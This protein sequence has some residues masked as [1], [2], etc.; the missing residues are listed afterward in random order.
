[1]HLFQ[2]FRSF[3]FSPFVDTRRPYV[4]AK[5]RVEIFC[6]RE[7]G[8]RTQNLSDH[9]PSTLTPSKKNTASRPLVFRKDLRSHIYHH[10]P[11]TIHTNSVIVLRQLRRIR[12]PRMGHRR[13]KL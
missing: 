4:S 1:M 11:S 2:V 12:N 3:R 10:A 13:P 9:L 7:F 5:F 8:E 6:E